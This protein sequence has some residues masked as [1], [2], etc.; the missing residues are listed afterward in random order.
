[1]ER[2]GKFDILELRMKSLSI[3]YDIH[4]CT[5]V[6]NMSKQPIL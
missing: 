3:N 1:M 6:R 5:A 2:K 4:I